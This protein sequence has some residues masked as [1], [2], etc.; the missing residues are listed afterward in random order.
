MLAPS[1]LARFAAE[2]ISPTPAL[3]EV[4]DT[5]WSVQWNLAAGEEIAQRIV[6]FPAITLSVEQGSVPAPY[7]VTRVRPGAW[8]RVIAGS[9]SVFAIRLRPAGLAVLS[10]LTPIGPAEEAI[11]AVAAPVFDLLQNIATADDQAVRADELILQALRA[12]PLTL[13]QRRA[14]AAVASLT[15]SPRVRPGRAVA[16]ELGISE[17]TLQRALRATVGVGPNDVARRIRLQEV[18]RLASSPNADMTQIAA[19][20]GYTD[21]AHLINEFRS[22]AGVSP[23]RYLRELQRG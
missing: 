21:Q 3:S 18:I 13:E 6:D 19:D 11:S 2:W 12:R 14:N 9:G 22:V 17:R 10:E 15:S 20:L 7:V 8:S 23:G 1:N 16:Q 5:Y 4:V